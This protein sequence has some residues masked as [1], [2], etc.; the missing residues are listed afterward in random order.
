MPE[1]IKKE[2]LGDPNLGQAGSPAKEEI[3]KELPRIETDN[4][5]FP[6]GKTIE[7]I[8]KETPPPPPP[9]DFKIAEIWIRS[10]QIM[11]DASESF[12]QDRCRALGVLEFCKDIIKTAQPPKKPNIIVPG[13]GSLGHKIMNFAR[14]LFKRRR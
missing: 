3:K 9:T 2:E 4:K 5:G 14:S 12:W 13:N 8:K 1:A 7:E 6:S 10:G 11:L